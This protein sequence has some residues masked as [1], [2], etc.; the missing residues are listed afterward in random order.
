MENKIYFCIDLKTFYASVEC[1]E[2]HL[3]PFNTN[4][5]VANPERGRGAICLAV[6]PKMKML[7]VKNRC[8]LYEI[9]KNINYIIAMPRMKKYIEYSANIY[10]I[11][12]K[13]FSK[14]DIHVYSIDEAFI[15]VSKYFKLYKVEPI[16]LVKEV[17]KEIKDT[18]GITATA[19]VGTNMYLAKVALDITAKHSVS[20]IGYLDE[21]KYKKD[22]GNHKPLTDFG[23]IGKGISESLKKMGIYTMNDIANA[24]PRKLYNKFGVNAKYL[25]D[26]S[27]GIEPCTIQEI[28]Q[29]KPKTNSIST[30][31]IL[32]KDYNYADAL[33]VT[34]EMVEL[35]S[36]E[37]IT[38]NLKTESINL[39]VGYSKDFIEPSK[40]SKKLEIA[41]N[42]YTDLL[43]EYEKLY[44][45]IVSKIEPI[46][47]IGIS[48]GKLSSDNYEQLNLFVNQE[49]KDKEKNIE[50]TINILKNK[51]GKN[52][53]LKGINLQENATTTVRNN[54]IGG[55]N[56]Y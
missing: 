53:L 48:F 8:R 51:F 36:L 9:P 22:L 6:S 44:S 31:Q 42:V 18:T 23:Q 45:K 35:L 11:Y 39:Y 5:V 32:F 13:Y 12:L 17:I 50:R 40:G 34:K 49:K 37:L 16:T 20:N 15:D 3:D 7:G 10:E 43:K 28:K 38:K 46:R 19:G 29:Y 25:I 54:L 21:E 33:L 14:D 47:R 2:R 27:K 41:T 55:H 26:H 52:L 24:E 56:A 1:V 4:L 30:N